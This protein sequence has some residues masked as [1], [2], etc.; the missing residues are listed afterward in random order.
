M[1]LASKHISFIYVNFPLNSRV[2]YKTVKG[3]NSTH[4]LGE[5]DCAFLACFKYTR[6]LCKNIGYKYNSEPIYRWGQVN[7][8]IAVKYLYIVYNGSMPSLNITQQFYITIASHC[9]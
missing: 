7:R 4:C 8:Q 3:L 6:L 5:L 2:Y 9:H 1:A